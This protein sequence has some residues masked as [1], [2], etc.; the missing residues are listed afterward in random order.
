[1][2]KIKYIFLLILTFIILYNPTLS[3]ATVYYVKSHGSDNNNGQSIAKAWKTIRQVSIT[4][5]SPGDTI[6]LEGGNIF[7]GINTVGAELWVGQSGTQNSPIVYTSYDTTNSGKRAIIKAD[8]ETFGIYIVKQNYIEIRNINITSNFNPFNPGGAVI[9]NN[10]GL[11]LLVNS[12]TNIR[13]I[14]I[15][16]DSCSISR[17]IGCGIISETSSSYAFGDV[18]ISNCRID[19]VGQHGIYCNAST[20]KG[21][22]K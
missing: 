10:H 6:K 11:Y 21:I 15:K 19:S 12:D 5:F 22:S 14:G 8:T 16:I 2:E 13:F 7:E 20:G 18:E 1:M 9:I 3:T 17:F 4:V